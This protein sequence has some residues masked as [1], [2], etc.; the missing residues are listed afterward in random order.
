MHVRLLFHVICT[1]IES[2]ASK[3][4]AGGFVEM[5]NDNGQT[6][7]RYGDTDNGPSIF[8]F[9]S[10][11]SDGNHNT[12]DDCDVNSNNNNNT[13]TD[14]NDSGKENDTH[15]HRQRHH[16]RNKTVSIGY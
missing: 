12:D 3:P 2:K 9:D 5:T 13:D 10:N 7:M 1:L 16:R 11:D 14:D 4:R 8:G 6:L 15:H